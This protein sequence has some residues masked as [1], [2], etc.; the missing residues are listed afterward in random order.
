M[1]GSDGFGVF[2]ISLAL[3]FGTGI[4]LSAAMA[5]AEGTRF[6]SVTTEL[7]TFLDSTSSTR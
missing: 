2:G 5:Y 4:P 1:F 6:D 3:T 7:S